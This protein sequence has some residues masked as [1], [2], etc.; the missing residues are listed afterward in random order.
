VLAACALAAAGA[1]TLA[2]PAPAADFGPV[3]PAIADGSPGSLRDVIE[4][5]ADSPGGDTVTLTAGATYT[6]TCDAGGQLT[7][8]PATPLTIVGNGATITIESTCDERILEHT[9]DGDG[10]L[11]LE[12][13]TI[14]G[15]EITSGGDGGGIRSETAVEIVG[16]TITDNEVGPGSSSGGGISAQGAV[17]VTDSVISAN[18]A[19]GRGGGISAQDT[20]TVTR[21]SIVGNTGNTSGGT[22]SGAGIS[23]FAADV[24]VVSSTISGNTAPGADGGGGGISTGGEPGDEVVTIVNSTIVGNTVA[25]RTGGGVLASNIVLVYSTVTG[26]AALEPANLDYVSLTSFA[27]VVAA[28]VG[29]G[30]CNGTGSTI[31]LGYNFADDDSCQFT[32]VAAGDREGAGLDPVL[33]ALASNGGP[34][35]TRLP[36]AGS[37]LVD[38]VPNAACQTAPLATGITT[39]QRAFARPQAGG[40]AC[41]IGAVEVQVEPPAVVTPTFTG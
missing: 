6:L 28:P 38:A 2:A 33:G 37:P 25:N 27:S 30:N 16:S 31:S 32:N 40:G 22:T 35:Q 26:N 23:T 21:S 3:D 7:H 8:D 10:L 9:G 24:T 4:N 13:V 20:V 15:G 19:S 29:G 39:D 5:E 11:R 18:T 36:L 34:T 12:N 41:D 1:V 14:T 17:T